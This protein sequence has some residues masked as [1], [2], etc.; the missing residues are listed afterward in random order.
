MLWLTDRPYRFLRDSH[1]SREPSLPGCL[2]R[3]GMPAAIHGTFSGTYSP[4]TARAICCIPLPLLPRR[5]RRT[6][7][8]PSST[9]RTSESE[10][11]MT[12]GCPSSLHHPSMRCCHG[13]KTTAS[14]VETH[15]CQPHTHGHEDPASVP[16]PGRA[17][18]PAS[19]TP[20]SVC[21][22]GPTRCSL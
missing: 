17:W 18:H 2:Q 21:G 22:H 11:Q 8:G 9:L 3:A 1:R 16:S 13:R 14:F 20:S 15:T 5:A 10:T 4:H 12:K 6:Q 19:I 7:W